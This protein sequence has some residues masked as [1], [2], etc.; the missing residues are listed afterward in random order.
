MV[1]SY[2]LYTF[3]SYRVY[4]PLPYH[5]WGD[6]CYGTDYRSHVTRPHH[7]VGAQ[8][9]TQYYINQFIQF[10]QKIRFKGKGYYLFKNLRNTYALKF[11]FSHR[12]YCFFPMLHSRRFAKFI[13]FFFNRSLPLLHHCTSSLRARRPIKIFTLRGLR[14]SRQVIYKK[15]GKETSYR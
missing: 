12:S 3:S 2:L 11:G 9:F 7:L 5:V 10:H 4:L 14:F 15:I 8:L 6:R 13:F 1:N